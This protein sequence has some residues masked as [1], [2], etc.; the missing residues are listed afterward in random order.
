M[1]KFRQLNNTD[2]D[3]NVLTQDLQVAFISDLNIVTTI[4]GVIC[5]TLTLFYGHYISEVKR[6]V[7]TLALIFI[8]FV[9]TIVFVR[10]DTDD[11]EFNLFIHQN[12]LTKLV[13][14]AGQGLFFGI[15]LLIAGNMCGK[16][17]RFLWEIIVFYNNS[18]ISRCQ[19]RA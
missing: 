12:C 2:L 3:D 17:K 7:A 15:T 14:F 8:L 1:Y 19:C 4:A 18:A 10:L 5:L 13:Y 6:I 11:C 16:K 9:V